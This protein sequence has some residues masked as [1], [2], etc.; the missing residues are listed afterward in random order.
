MDVNARIVPGVR[1]CD[2][3]RTW[4]GWRPV[5]TDRLPILGPVSDETLIYVTGFI[6]LGLAMA[7]AVAESVVSALTSGDWSKIP[8]DFSPDCK[9]ALAH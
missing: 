5:A 2:L 3:L 1:Q 6:G 8:A 4:R 9:G 7:P